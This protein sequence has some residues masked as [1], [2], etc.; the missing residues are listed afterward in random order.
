MRRSILMLLIATTAVALI[1]QGSK[2]L[3]GNF[4]AADESA[5]LFPGLSL[6]RTRNEGV[7]FGM[8]AGR[9]LL[10]YALVAASLAGLL[11]FYWR[12]AK[13]PYA[14]LATALLLGGAAGNLIDRASL[15]YVRDFID[16]VHWP[17]FNLA[18]VA[19]TFGV[20]GLFLL[21]LGRGT[22]DV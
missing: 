19:I 10:V 9:P 5:S 22:A 20:V 21:P 2:E 7:A 15:G 11:A 17:A 13:Q 14:W 18:D 3:A 6:S 1:D 16:P 8:L 12:H 4:L